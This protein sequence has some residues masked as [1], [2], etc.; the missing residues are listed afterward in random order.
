MM[1]EIKEK[2]LEEWYIIPSTLQKVLKSNNNEVNKIRQTARKTMEKF[3]HRIS[4]RFVNAFILLTVKCIH[5]DTLPSH[6][7]DIEKLTYCNVR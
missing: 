4:F 3:I 1:M 5:T 6:I 2:N 7:I